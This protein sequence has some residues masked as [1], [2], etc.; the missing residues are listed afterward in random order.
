[1]KDFKKGVKEQAAQFDKVL[2]SSFL[3][4]QCIILLNSDK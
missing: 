3:W 1:M 4:V 2:R